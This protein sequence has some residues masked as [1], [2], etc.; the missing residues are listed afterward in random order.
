MAIESPRPD[1]QSIPATREKEKTMQ[2]QK[3]VPH[4]TVSPVTKEKRKQRLAERREERRIKN[5]ALREWNSPQMQNFKR[6]ALQLGANIYAA[7][8]KL[9][10]QGE[11]ILFLNPDPWILPNKRRAFIE[12]CV[13]RNRSGN[14]RRGI[15]LIDTVESDNAMKDGIDGTIA[16]EIG[17][18]VFMFVNGRKKHWDKERSPKQTVLAAFRREGFRASP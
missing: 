2:T 16:H 7:T 17:H 6:L 13:K 3:S 18:H 10:K 12:A 4:Y 15:I 11:Y 8:S 5:E 14:G 9:S 1:F